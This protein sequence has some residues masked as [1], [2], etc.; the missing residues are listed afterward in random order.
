[1]KIL[2]FIK[3]ALS[4]LGW[5]AGKTKTKFDDKAIN[6]LKGV[7]T[8][9]PDI[10]PSILNIARFGKDTIDEEQEK[11]KG[12]KEELKALKIAYRVVK[13]APKGEVEKVVKAVK[14]EL[15]KK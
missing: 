6:F 13:N 3:P 14:A 10:I 1:M 9:C 8:N 4:L 15:K 12:S 5:L 7:L 2:F 11:F